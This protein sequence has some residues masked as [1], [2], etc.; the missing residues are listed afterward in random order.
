VLAL[1]F[2]LVLGSLAGVPGVFLALSFFGLLLH[3]GERLVGDGGD[4]LGEDALH[5]VRLGARE[6]LAQVPDLRGVPLDVVLVAADAH[7]DPLALAGDDASVRHRD[8]HL[9]PLQSQLL[10]LVLETHL[11]LAQGVGQLRRARV[12]SEGASKEEKGQKRERRA[13]FKRVASFRTSV[14]VN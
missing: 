11:G 9:R 4:E 3:A 5:E 10:A 12:R 14:F 2:V 6:G 8:Q 1:L 13:A 7:A